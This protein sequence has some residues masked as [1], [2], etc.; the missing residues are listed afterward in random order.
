MSKIVAPE[1]PVCAEGD[2]DLGSVSFSNQLDAGETL[3]GTPLVVEVDTTDLTISNKTVSTAILEIN[4]VNVPIGEAVQFK[5]SG[6]LKETGV[7][8]LK[9]T[10][11]TTSTPARTLVRYVRFDVED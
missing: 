6:M 7:Y 5:V 4:E 11:T 2:T 8:K 3:T 9:I 1:R 10:V